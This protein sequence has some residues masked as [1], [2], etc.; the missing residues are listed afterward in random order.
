MVRDPAT[1]PPV[2][3]SPG[4]DGGDP[5]TTTSAT[6]MGVPKSDDCESQEPRVA[7]NL[8]EGG[9][10]PAIPVVSAYLVAVDETMASNVGRSPN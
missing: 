9:N 3:D 2:V 5:S 4:Y 10:G 1:P 8:V 6:A 7:A